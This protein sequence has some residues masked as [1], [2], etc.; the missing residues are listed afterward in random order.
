MNLASLFEIEQ[1]PNENLKSYP[2]RFMEIRLKT[3]DCSSNWVAMMNGIKNLGIWTSIA[4]R[5]PN[6]FDDL[7]D[8][9]DKYI[10]MEDLEFLLKNS[11]Q[12]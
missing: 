5:K 6:S 1:K 7:L 11:Y 8:R 9:F 2:K 3:E 12:S 10:T 4:K